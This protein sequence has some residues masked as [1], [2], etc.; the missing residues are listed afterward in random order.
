MPPQAL[1]LVDQIQENWPTAGDLNIGEECLRLFE[2]FI[3]LSSEYALF[4]F[5]HF[6]NGGVMQDPQNPLNKM[7]EI[8]SWVISRVDENFATFGI[9]LH[10][11][12]LEQSHKLEAL[13]SL[14]VNK[15]L[16]A[17]RQV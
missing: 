7:E 10:E 3:H 13:R 6:S 9:Q 4:A 12:V 5:H 17:V 15:P 14:A 16:R 2:C 8:T 1:D 11:E